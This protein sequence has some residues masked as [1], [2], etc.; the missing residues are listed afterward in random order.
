VV[1]S[2][3]GKEKI[4]IVA[5]RHD[6]LVRQYNNCANS[7]EYT[8]IGSAFSIVLKDLNTP[9]QAPRRDAY[10]KVQEGKPGQWVS[11]EHRTKNCNDLGYEIAKRQLVVHDKEFIQQAKLVQ[12]DGDKPV[13]DKSMTFDWVMALAGV[14]QLLRNIPKMEFH[15]TSVKYKEN[16]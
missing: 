12:R 4:D 15:V 16:L 7:Y 5:Q 8:G 10:G 14:V 13:M 11:Q 1:C 9:N 3:T 6:Y 2:A